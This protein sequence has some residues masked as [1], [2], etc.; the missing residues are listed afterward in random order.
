MRPVPVDRSRMSFFKIRGPSSISDLGRGDLSFRCSKCDAV[1][2]ERV[3]ESS[4]RG[5]KVRC[6]HCASISVV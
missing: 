5:L 4:V 2:F 1:L 3:D 6:P